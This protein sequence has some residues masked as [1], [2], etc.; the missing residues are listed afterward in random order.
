LWLMRDLHL[1]IKIV[2]S[3]IVFGVLIVALRI[4]TLAM[5]KTILGRRKANV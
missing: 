3:A 5:V 2:V 4:I 1:A